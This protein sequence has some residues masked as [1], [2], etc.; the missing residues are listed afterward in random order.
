MRQ[1]IF[2]AR[3]E[4][5]RKHNADPTATWKA[6]VNQLTDKTDEEYQKLLG[7]DTRKRPIESDQKISPKYLQSSRRINANGMSNSQAVRL[8]G[9]V[10][11]RMEGV[12]TGVKDQG[13]CGSCWSFAAAETIESHFAIKTG[14]LPTLSQQHILGCTQNPNQ[15]GG[16]GGC[17]GAT[18]ELAYDMIIKSGGIA[19]EW[20]YPYLSYWG[21][22]QK[23]I[24]SNY[25][26]AVVK[27]ADYVMLPSNEYEPLIEAVA[28]QG[29]I[30]ISVDASA[31]SSY[32]FG[33]FNGCN[34]TNPDLNHA[35]QLVGY[36]TDP[37]F[38]AYWLVRN[39]WSPAW[40]EFGYIRLARETNN[41]TCGVDLTPL[42]GSG[43]VGGPPSVIVCGTC[44][45]LYDNVYPII[46]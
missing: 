12:V 45:I 7:F 11:W 18:V 14:Q 44:G 5:I 22:N 38:G 37:K 31:W 23:C 42:D 35:V 24:F 20:T 9:S 40:G 21:Q 10:D 15:C 8:P 29:P 19:S 28:T 6:G 32:E 36:G 25:T 13:Q 16:T 17:G 2:E 43:C 27:L 33:V 46:A 3:L 1:N 4:G 26:P 30:A 34:Q 39:S 41:N